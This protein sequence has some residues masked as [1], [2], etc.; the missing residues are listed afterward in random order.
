MHINKAVNSVIE[1]YQSGDFQKAES[2]CKKILIKRPKNVDALHFLGVIYSTRGQHDLAIDHIRRA[3]LIDPNFAD[4]YNNLGN[5]FQKIN[6]P[7]E[8]ISCYQK[9]L[10]LNPQSAIT[11]Y[12]L[13]VSLQDKGRIDEAILHYREALQ[14]N[15]SSCGLLNNLGLAFQK[16]G[17]LDE[18]I[19][20]YQNAIKLNP[21]FAEAYCNL[22]NAMKDKQ[23]LDEALV[24]YQKALQLNPEYADVYN[25]LGIVFREQGQPDEVVIAYCEK[26]LEINPDHAEAYCQLTYQMQRTCNWQKLEVMTAKLDRLTRRA[27]NAG[28]RPA[29]TPF[30]SITRHAD[31]SLNYAIAKSWSRDI[32]MAMSSLNLHF[33]FDA[34]RTDRTKIVIGYLSNDF[35][36]HATAHLML[37][38][39]G[40][41][42]RDNFKI[43]CYSYGK[44]D[45]SYYR[46]RIEQDSNK[47]I[48][49]SGLSDE[50]SAR[51]IHEDQVDILV[52]LK[53][54]TK[55]SR[56]AISALRPAPVQISYLGF[57]G[58]TGADFI[59][60]I[61]SD[62]IVTPEEH[63]LFYSEKFVYMPDCYQVNDYTQAISE[64]EWKKVDFGLPENTFIFCSFNQPYK[65]DPLIFDV[66]M[67]ILLKISESILWLGF[68][69]KIVEEHLRLEAEKRG[70]QSQRLIFAGGLQKNEHLSRL[71][72]ADLALD[73]RIVNGHTTTSDALWAGVPVITLQGSHFSSRVSSSILS[74]MRLPQ[75]ITH[76]LEDYEALAVR[77]AS[78]PVE[79]QE[80][81]QKIAE[82]RLTAP[83]FDTPRFVINL[84]TAYKQMWEIYHAGEKTRVI[85][86]LES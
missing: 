67:K 4:A 8:A 84:E 15:F 36:N 19:S 73:T 32:S 82:N 39:F 61:I 63:K 38:L 12:N 74:A 83:L 44:D 7:D 77:L 49:I 78:A 55:D 52:D 70:V 57:P 37:S 62:R 47:F 64:K 58:T 66:W 56:L 41:H 53:G 2:I 86:V 48:D 81:R 31:A 13:G 71:R 6:Q 17:Q 60:Y 26:A 79:L 40:L 10:N 28:T 76:S 11:H 80:I 69:N 65:I 22:G 68:A 54:H 18:A 21:G 45:G 43:Y 50:A 75:L 14:F 29:E 46:S 27:L 72:L 16:K 35:G 33:S 25:N 59:D 85:E 30:M 51:R 24:L 23:H 42:N 20:F 34:K 9:A 1:Y 3:L 5:I